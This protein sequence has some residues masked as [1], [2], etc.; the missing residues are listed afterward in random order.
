M[1]HVRV[2]LCPHGGQPRR[3][4]G[5]HLTR[6]SPL[7]TAPI[8][9]ASTSC[10]PAPA[11]SRAQRK[12]LCW[13]RGADEPHAGCSHRPCP[14]PCQARRHQVLRGT[15]QDSPR[16][17]Q[18][19]VCRRVREHRD[20]SRVGSCGREQARGRAGGVSPG[21]APDGSRPHRTAPTVPGAPPCSRPGSPATGPRTLG[22]TGA[23]RQGRVTS[24]TG[25]G[26]TARLAAPSPTHPMVGLWGT[27]WQGWAQV[28]G[29]SSGTCGHPWSDLC[30]RPSSVSEAS[31]AVNRRHLCSRPRCC[32][33]PRAVVRRSGHSIS[34]S[35]LRGQRAQTQGSP[36]HPAPLPGHTYSSQSNL[37]AIM[38]SWYT[39][40]VLMAQTWVRGPA[41]QLGLTALSVLT[42]QPQGAA[43]SWPQQVQP[44]PCLGRSTQSPGRA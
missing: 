44:A 4:D 13:G 42:L 20:A 6:A 39:S 18:Q 25:E 28:P 12:V 23:G 3:R 1:A 24:R 26:T 7:R 17:Q 43:N 9:T 37:G 27:G 29:V 19:Q 11:A 31:R 32:R 30:T 21:H 14:G 35:G 16:C 41:P 36:P 34:H 8:S 2:T 38:S 40:A 5:S 10:S 15:G 33:R 22:C